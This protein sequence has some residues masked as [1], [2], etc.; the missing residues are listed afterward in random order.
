[1]RILAVATALAAVVAADLHAEPGAVPTAAEDHARLVRLLGLGELRRGADGDPESPFAPNYEESRANDSLA[2]LPDALGGESGRRVDTADD[3]WRRRR[4]EIVERFDREI[5]GRVP[6]S[7]PDVAWRSGPATAG[8]IGAIPVR[9]LAVTGVV[10]DAVAPWIDV[11]I[12]LTV[13]VPETATGAVPAVLQITY[14]PEFLARLRERFSAEQ[15][16]AFRGP[17]PAWQEQVAARGWAVAEFV[18]T[19]IQADSGDGLSAGIVGLA[20]RGEPRDA[21]DWGALRACLRQLVGRGRRQT[22]A[23][24]LRRADRIHR[25]H[26]RVSLGR[27]QFPQVRGPADR[28]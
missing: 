8:R 6:A 26:R 4:P 24:E 28:R 15:R 25:G 16:A 2:S 11:E 23:Q 27:R 9:T 3:W 20:N 21:D 17:G 18:A 7:V 22:V 14:G 1:M 13:S 5:Y 10:D 19:S 12:A